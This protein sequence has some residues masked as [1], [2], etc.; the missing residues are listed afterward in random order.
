MGLNI[1]NHIQSESKNI[2]IKH[3]GTAQRKQE[4]LFT[5][6]KRTIL[7]HNIF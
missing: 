7:V 1:S 4:D 5:T 3:T 2:H 6:T